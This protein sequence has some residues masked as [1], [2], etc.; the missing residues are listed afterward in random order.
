MHDIIIYMYKCMCYWRSVNV[1]TFFMWLLILFLHGFPEACLHVHV[2]VHVSNA[3][4]IICN[5]QY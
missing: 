4:I 3:Y 1:Y 2:H 5:M